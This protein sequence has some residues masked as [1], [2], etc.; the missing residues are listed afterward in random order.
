MAAETRLRT[1]GHVVVDALRAC[2]ADA[3]FGL[4]GI[5][6]LAIWEGLRESPDVRVCALRTELAAGFAA[7]GYARSTGRTAVLLTTTGPGSLV[8]ACALMEARTAFVPLVNVVSQIPRGIIDQGR[9]FL[10]ELERQTDVFEPLTKAVLRAQTAAAIAPTLA[11]AF[12]IAATAPAGPVMVEVPVDVLEGSTAVRVPRRLDAAAAAPAGAAPCDVER[13]AALLAGSERPVLWAGSGVLRA[14]AWDELR[15]L[16][17]RLD[18]PVATT[19]MG[20]GAL[21]DSHPLAVGGGC[22]EGAVIELLRTADVVLAVGTELGAETT[23]QWSLE[24]DGDLI[25][26]DVRAEHIG[27]AYDVAV[28]LVGCARPTLAALAACVPRADRDGARRAAAVRAR[29]AAG[30]AGMDRE[31][32]LELLATLRAALPADAVTAFDMTILGYWAAPHFRVER[33]RSFLYPLGSGTLGYAWPAA[34]GAK[35]GAPDAPVVAVHGDGGF[36]YA[37]QELASARQNGIA[38]KLVLVDDGRYGILDRYQRDAYGAT[39]AVDL[40]GPDLAALAAAYGVPCFDCDAAGFGD[41]LDAAL[42]VE[43]PAVCLLRHTLRVADATP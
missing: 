13:A 16:A 7:D 26:L 39:F 25:Q 15:V 42:A 22:D 33:P 8:A 18:A 3:V 37:S 30:L 14:A 20:R 40:A 24:L 10:H 34:L 38:A 28:P 1:G 17:E 31:P 19:F 41:A 23:G 36:L 43:G 29:I 27:L 9:G 32:E 2:G 35:V 21:P 11:E 4:P 12:R 5:H 6:A